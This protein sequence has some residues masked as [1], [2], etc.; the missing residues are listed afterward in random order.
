MNNPNVVSDKRFDSPPITMTSG[1]AQLTFRQN[2]NLE[3]SFDGGVLEISIGGAVFQD[4]VAA[5][6]SFVTGGYNAAVNSSFSNPLAGRQAWSGN[7]NGFVTTTVNLPPS[8]GGQNIVLRWR[9]GSDNAVSGLGWR[10]DNIAITCA[11]TPTIFVEAGTNNLAAVDSV[12][13]MRGP[14]ALTN[15]QNYSSDQ[16]TRILFFT[17]DLGFAQSTQPNI[18]ILSVQLSGNSY[19]VE[20]VGPNA[21]IGGSAIVFRLPDGLSPGTYALGVRRNGVNSTN[22]PNLQIISSPSSPAAAPQSNKT[23][24]AKYLLVSLIDLIL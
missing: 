8:A 18:S 3:D 17:T 10:I 20:S 13:L 23:E 11:S 19:A 4:I 5:G 7:S 22:A 6:G 14:F 12:T 15:T 9:M 16:R 2:R 24:L 21:T 1:P